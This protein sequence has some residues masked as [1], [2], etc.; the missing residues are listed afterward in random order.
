M[1]GLFKLGSKTLML[2]VKI[3]LV[4]FAEVEKVRMLKITKLQ[5][6]LIKKAKKTLGIILLSHTFI[7]TS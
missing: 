4:S 3:F 7:H 1:L 5:D 2:V 6:W